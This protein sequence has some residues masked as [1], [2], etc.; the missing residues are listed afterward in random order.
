MLGNIWIVNECLSVARRA[1]SRKQIQLE[2]INIKVFSSTPVPVISMSLEPCCSAAGARKMSTGLTWSH[3]STRQF[4]LFL[5][6]CKSN[7]KDVRH[8]CKIQVIIVF[9]Y[10]SQAQERADGNFSF[11]SMLAQCEDA[12]R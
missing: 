1:W 9:Q 10:I 5:R 11:G 4:N 12:V 8:R 7:F 6:K 3:R 2:T